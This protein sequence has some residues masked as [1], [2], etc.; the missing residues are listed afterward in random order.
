MEYITLEVGCWSGL[1]AIIGFAFSVYAVVFWNS[2]FGPLTRAD[3][4]ARYSAVTL[5]TLGCQILLSASSQHSGC[6]DT[7]FLIHPSIF[8]ILRSVGAATTARWR[9][10]I[11]GVKTSVSALPGRCKSKQLRT[12]SYPFQQLI[13][14]EPNG[15]LHG[16]IIA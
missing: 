1:P 7:Q 8:L 6:A 2:T 16:T 4:A 11:S 12:W 9:A 10:V 3:L 5:S 14:R 15:N 13:R